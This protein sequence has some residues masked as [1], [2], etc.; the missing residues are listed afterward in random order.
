MP[1]LPPAPLSCLPPEVPPE[2]VVCPCG[3]ASDSAAASAGGLASPASE[4]ATT[5]SD[6]ASASASARAARCSG[7][8]EAFLVDMLSRNGEAAAGS[9]IGRAPPASTSGFTPACYNPAV[10]QKS[11]NSPRPANATQPNA[12]TA[13]P[14]RWPRSRASRH[15]VNIAYSPAARR[16]LGPTLRE[17]AR[18]RIAYREVSDEE[19]GRMSGSSHH[20]GV[21]MLVRRAQAPSFPSSRRARTPN[22]LIVALDHV[23]NPHNAGAILRTAA[24]FGV[25]GLVYRRRR[26]RIADACGAARRRRRRRAR[27][28][29]A[30]RRHRPPRSKACA[31]TG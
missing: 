2:P 23:G 3:A 17:A 24:F 8:M 1:P 13:F 10:P 5:I 11:P 31:R 18:R 21:C 20:E 29:R 27:A 22:G 16:A 7:R 4:H 25:R 15:I 26:A 19:L 30:Q 9:S 28:D 14:P 6:G 12:C